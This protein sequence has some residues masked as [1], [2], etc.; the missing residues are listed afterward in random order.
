MVIGYGIRYLSPK[1][2]CTEASIHTSSNE[3]VSA[4]NWEKDFLKLPFKGFIFHCIYR[5]RGY[6]YK[7][8]N[9]Y[10]K[11]NTGTVKA[12]SKIL[13]TTKKQ[14]QGIEDKNLPFPHISEEKNT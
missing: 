11:E 6:S 1:G 12:V 7:E 3:I 4:V 8:T 13:N 9:I 2:V 5:S 10:Q 14:S